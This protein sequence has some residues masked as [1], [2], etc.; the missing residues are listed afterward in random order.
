MQA[1][2]EFADDCHGD[3]PLIAGIRLLPFK[4]GHKLLLQRLRSP[5]AVGGR[6]RPEKLFEAIHICS[7][8]YALAVSELYYAPIWTRVRVWFWSFM[9]SYRASRDATFVPSS[10]AALWEYIQ[11]CERDPKNIFVKT[12]VPR[13]PVPHIPLLVEELCA[14]YNYTPEQVL[15]LSMRK[16]IILRFQSLIKPDSGL[17]WRESWQERQEE[18]HAE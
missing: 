1:D 5:F 12:S 4:V 8:S 16:A 11:D 2:L 7:R 3:I 14:A 9:M 6:V 17:K 13:T 15:E 18:S 10:A